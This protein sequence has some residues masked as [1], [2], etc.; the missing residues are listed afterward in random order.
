MLPEQNPLDEQAG[1]AMANE[2][3]NQLR[4]YL[5]EAAREQA[6]RD[7]VNRLQQE[8]RAQRIDRYNELADTLAAMDALE[9]QF[10]MEAGEE[11]Q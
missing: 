10:M 9:A 4:E 5:E 11:R 2:W 8:P 6:V 3:D 7:M 1:E